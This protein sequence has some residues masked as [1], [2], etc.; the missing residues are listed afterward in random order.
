MPVPDEV[1]EY[2]NSVNGIKNLKSSLQ[3]WLESSWDETEEQIDRIYEVVREFLYYGKLDFGYLV[4]APDLYLIKNKDK[5]HFYW[6]AD[7]IDQDGTPYWSQQNG[8]F[9]CNYD[10]F[11]AKLLKGLQSFASDMRRQITLIA[12]DKPS[13]VEVNVDQLNENQAQY[14][15]LVL[16]LETNTLS[17]VDEPDWA[18]ILD[19]IR[20]ILDHETS[21]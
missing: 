20:L 13:G 11:M 3:S 6:I 17:Y 2:V 18:N 1:F 15:D 7:H 8:E 19:K 9:H 14:E 12:A 10:D 4:G 16:A 5:I 21:A